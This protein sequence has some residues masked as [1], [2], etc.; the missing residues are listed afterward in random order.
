MD[1]VSKW[2]EKRKAYAVGSGT[3]YSLMC[4][5]IAHSVSKLGIAQTQT[6]FRK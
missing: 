2:I 1:V 5:R 6:I 4:P 3:S